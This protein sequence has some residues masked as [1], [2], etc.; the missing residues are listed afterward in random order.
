MPSE[1]AIARNSTLSRHQADVGAKGSLR[2]AEVRCA[3][4][5]MVDTNSSGMGRTKTRGII[6]DI[7]GVWP[8]I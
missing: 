7:A 4:Q 2:G 5:A 3:A 8:G 1:H 6:A